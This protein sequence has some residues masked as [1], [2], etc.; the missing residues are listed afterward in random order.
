MKSI[1]GRNWEEINLNKRLI[2][3]VKTEHELNEIQTKIVISRNFTKEEIYTI[4]NDLEF[5]NPFQKTADFLLA[6]DLIKKH[7]DNKDNI[8]IVGD[9]DVDGCVS[10]SLLV[11]FFKKIKSKINFYI[12]DRFKDG[13]GAS[14]FLIKKL[15]DFYK[16]N[17][18]IFVDCGSTSHE[19][20]KFLKEQ[21]ISS[22]IIDHH[23]TRKPYPHTD[24]FI[25][26]KKICDYEK[27]DYLCSAL[28]TYLL[29][30]IYLKK[31]KLKISILDERINILIATVADVMPIR[32]INRILALSVLKNYDISKNFLISYLFNIQKKRKKLELD[33]LGYLIAPILNSAGRLDNAN[34]VVELLSS[35]IE[36]YKIQILNKIC[37]LNNQR[38]IL[39]QRFFHNLDL[40]KLYKKKGVL[41]IYKTDIPEGI[42]GIIASRI[43]DLFNKPCIV[44]TNSNNIIKGSARSTTSFNIGEFINK[45]LNEKILLSGGG[46]NLAAGVSLLKSKIVKFEKFINSYYIKSNHNNKNFYISKILP[47]AVNK[48][49]FYYIKT[50]GPFGNQNQNPIFL[51]EQ[52]KIIKPMIVKEKFISCF[53]QK[54]KKL[55]KAIFFGNLNT[56]ISYE[57]LN[58][59]NY[60]DIIVNFKENNWNNKSTIELEIID[61]IKNTNKT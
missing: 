32:G 22:L 34:Q 5:K 30:D 39:E 35:D 60:F 14:K 46:H 25:N 21:K 24:V 8:L 31:N 3:K 7:V 6:T 61:L 20:L 40:T 33:D 1:S 27:Y 43:K 47:D 23:N 37:N 13:Y 16:P 57:I 29:V 10:V 11:N 49:F 36:Q 18:I 45:A 19:A 4:T 17:L 42:I 53:I 48:K 56:K 55:I 41:F 54:N 26:P 28:L 2:E 59:K 58:S 44:F 51:L 15:V 9:Y 38:K 52:I 12:P 50:L